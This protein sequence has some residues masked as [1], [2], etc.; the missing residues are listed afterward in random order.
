MRLLGL[1][2]K[3][4]LQ[5]LL[6]SLGWIALGEASTM[7]QGHRSRPIERPSGRGAKTSCQV[8]AYPP[9]AIEAVPLAPL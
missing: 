7:H 6:W 8:P 3:R 1:S 9:N 4:S 5:P 2:H